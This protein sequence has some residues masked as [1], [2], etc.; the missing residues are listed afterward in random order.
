MKQITFGK[1]LDLKPV[2][3]VDIYLFLGHKLIPNLHSR[4]SPSNK[5][6][7][8]PFWSHIERSIFQTLWKNYS[9]PDFLFL[10]L[11]TSNFGYSLI[12]WFPLTVQSF[13]VRLDNIDLRHFIRVPPL[14]FFDFVIYQ[15][16]IGGTLCIIS[17]LS[18]LTETLH[19]QR[20]S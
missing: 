19:S 14:M 6:G 5:K 18:N 3:N 10:K 8:K 17:M 15:K 1:E 9:C 4:R 7:P 16:F 2:P 13:S 20:K 11:E 12:I